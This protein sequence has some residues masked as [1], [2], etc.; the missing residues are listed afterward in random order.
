MEA[1]VSG[2]AHIHLPSHAEQD[3]PTQPLMFL[4]SWSFSRSQI[5]PSSVSI[6]FSPPPHPLDMFYR[7]QKTTI[8]PFEIRTALPEYVA[9]L[10]LGQPMPRP[11]WMSLMLHAECEHICMLVQQARSNKS[12][13][14]TL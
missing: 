12:K 9:R 8:S 11:T 13:L 1:E 4:A 2:Q 14:S 5:S 7:T 6:V 3:A 10:Y